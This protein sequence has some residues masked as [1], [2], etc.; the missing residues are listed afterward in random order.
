MAS[1]IAEKLAAVG[2]GMRAAA[3]QHGRAPDAVRL[4]AV[5]KTHNRASIRAAFAAGQRDFGEN[6][7]QEALDKM[8]ELTDLPLVWHFIG[9]I[10]SNKTRALASYFDWVHTVDRVKVAQRLSAQRPAERGPL[11]VLLQV[12]ISAEASKAGCT[13]AE[14]PGLASSVAALPLLRL[15]GLM[16]IPAPE[17][18][19]ARQ[20]AA[21]R[22]LADAARALRAA[23]H[24]DCTELSMGMSQDYQAAIAEGATLVRIGSDIF[25]PRPESRVQGT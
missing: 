2:A 16:A 6:Y 7:L 12:N 14:L 24:A 4:I 21:F 8:Q 18:S 3:V 23:G 25:G 11:N 20:R 13:L 22:Q 17:A 15:R 10:Q 1:S 5:S 19:A 9:P